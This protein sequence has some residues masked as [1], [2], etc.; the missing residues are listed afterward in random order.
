MSTAAPSNR[1][2]LSHKLQEM[3]YR[4][5]GS[6]GLEVSV[7]S[8]GCMR[9][10]DD[11]EL[12]RRLLGRAVDLGL[13]YF[14][15]TR[16]YLGGTCQ[17]R[18]AEGLQGRTKGVIVSGKTG[19]SADTTAFG[20][21]REIERQ[22]DILGL[23]HF[24]FFQVGW[25]GWDR[26]AHLLKRG[27]VLDALRRAQDEGLVH[28]I[29]FTGHDRPENFIRCIETGL[30]DCV[31]VPYSLINR[32]YEKL[33]ARA[34][35]L[36]VG[37]VAMCPVGGGLLA[38]ASPRMQEAMGTTEPLHRVSLRFVLSNSGISTACSGMNTVEM[39]EEN[40]ACV[41]DFDPGS[42]GDFQAISGA[43][44][45]MHASL[46]GM[47]C[48]NCKYCMPCKNGLDIP[49]FMEAHRLAVCLGFE[50]FQ[51][52]RISAMPE[53]SRPSACNRCGAC[54]ERCPN[55]LPIRRRMKELAGLG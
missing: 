24:K 18:T 36:G 44:D 26:I 6:T 49:Q 32:S 7:L 54:E 1:E 21:R 19:I 12:N 16:G 20:F 30:F 37:V 39:L 55:H 33:I 5:L 2:A 29:G 22:L 13:N 28:H 14:E 35:E 34:R 9:L 11:V 4:P 31:T 40:A 23:D 17:H 41:R 52:K 43:V 27:G 51:K 46:D 50:D 3:R 48:T 47:I 8:F 42:G 53:A 25:F 15:T 45:R 10:K 38:E